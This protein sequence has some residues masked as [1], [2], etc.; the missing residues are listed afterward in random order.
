MHACLS[1]C[2]IYIQIAC[3]PIVLGRKNKH[4]T[5]TVGLKCAVRIANRVTQRD[6]PNI[7]VDLCDWREIIVKTSVSIYI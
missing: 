5:Y 6:I 7:I 2:V 4:D 1:Y 3:Q